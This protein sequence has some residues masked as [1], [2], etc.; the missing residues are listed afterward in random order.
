MAAILLLLLIMA[1]PPAPTV[2]IT[3]SNSA[4]STS[5]PSSP[6]AIDVAT[7]AHNRIFF[8]YVVVL[9]LTVIG[10][11]WVWI[12]GNR[13]NDAVRAEAGARIEEAKRG[14]S[15][16]NL[17]I[18]ELT[19]ENLKLQALLLP[20]RVPIRPKDGDS[21]RIS[22]HAKVVK[23]AGTYALIQSVPDFEA[24][25]LAFDISSALINA[26]WQADIVDED[27]T[28]V[29]PRLIKS[30][31][32]IVTLEPSWAFKRAKDAV[33]QSKSGEAAN[34]LAGLL[35]LD[36]APTSGPVS[37]GVRWEPEFKGHTT[38]ILKAIVTLPD[39]AVLILVGMK[40]VDGIL[41]G[42]QDAPTVSSK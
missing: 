20:R 39:G 16:A 8:V 38:P 19:N 13:M 4:P 36:L 15:E 41:G 26:G 30:G 37:V 25:L 28:H 10:T 42:R 23:H 17:R 34:A 9:A 35:A 11:V 29:F 1:T 12:S 21:E 2:T 3:S 5:Q 6:S 22:R 40:P 33:A 18:A 31:V 32:R 7:R 27:R 14:I 24:Q